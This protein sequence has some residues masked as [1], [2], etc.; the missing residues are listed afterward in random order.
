MSNDT[1]W[2]VLLGLGALPAAI[3]AVCSYIEI[4]IKQ[5]VIHEEHETIQSALRKDMYRM[6]AD[7]VIIYELFQ[8][9]DT[10]KNL[11][12]T[13][14]G[15]FIYD[16]AFCKSIQNLFIFSNCHSR[17]WGEFVWRCNYQ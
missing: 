12:A 3:V 9:W 17:R 1:K 10:W 8:H 11:I 6:E 16:V 2:R 13:G 4:R 14:G 15:W 7:N 5:R